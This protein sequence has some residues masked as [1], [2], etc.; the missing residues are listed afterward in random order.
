M[1]L[2]SITPAV[3]NMKKLYL[4]ET[5]AT[6]P[7]LFITTPGADPSVELR[8]LASKEVGLSNFFEVGIFSFSHG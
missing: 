8:D 1:G 5:S 6:E 2:K 4:E 3:L 7:I